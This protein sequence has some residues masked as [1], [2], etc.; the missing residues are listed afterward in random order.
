MT[1]V[2]IGMYDKETEKPV[3]FFFL[4]LNWEHIFL[5]CSIAVLTCLCSF[6]R[7]HA[8]VVIPFFF[9]FFLAA[10][11]AGPASRPQ[12]NPSGATPGPARQPRLPDFARSHYLVLIK[13]WDNQSHKQLLRNNRE[14][15]H[16]FY[17]CVCVCLCG[18]V[19]SCSDMSSSLWP[20]GL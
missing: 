10:A 13:L 7:N 8:C 18:C 3:F 12:A 20:P 16:V 2:Y 17:L 1:K 5:S 9:F 19:Y 4:F 11:R 6:E 14:R 15:S